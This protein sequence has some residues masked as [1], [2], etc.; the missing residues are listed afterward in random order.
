MD[1]LTAHSY[2]AMGDTIE[3]TSDYWREHFLLLLPLT[4]H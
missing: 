2:L 3:F 1:L 4:I